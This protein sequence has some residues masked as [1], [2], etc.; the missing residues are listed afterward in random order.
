MRMLTVTI[1]F[2]SLQTLG[3]EIKVEY[4]KKHDFSRYKTFSFGESRVVT[5]SEQKQV[6]DATIDK[7]IRGGVTRELEYKGM[8]RVDSLADLLVT[9]ALIN[10]PRSDAQAIGPLGMTPGSNDRTWSR[11]YTETTLI[12][13]L[14]NHGNFLV[15]RVTGLADVTGR[16][17]E[18]AIDAIIVRGMKKFPRRGKKK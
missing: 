13:D 1:L 3:Q 5:S 14:N 4:D 2:I 15:W 11:N 16:D 17:A 9:Y 7:W 8:K 10:E 12:I 6:S 18:R